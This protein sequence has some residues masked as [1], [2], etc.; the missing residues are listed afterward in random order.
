MKSEFQAK[1]MESVRVR[2][3]SAVIEPDEAQKKIAIETLKKHYG[4]MFPELFL[5][6]GIVVEKKGEPPPPKKNILPRTG[7]EKYDAVLTQC[8]SNLAHVNPNLKNVFLRAFK[9]A[10]E[11]SIAPLSDREKAILPPEKLPALVADPVQARQVI[12]QIEKAQEAVSSPLGGMR[13]S[14]FASIPIEK[15]RWVIECLLPEGLTVLGA[16]AF[17]GKSILLVQMVEHIIRG[18]AFLGQF[19]TPGADALYF[20]FEKAQYEIVSRTAGISEKTKGQIKHD[21]IYYAIDTPGLP[22]T[23]EELSE[24]CERHLETTP[25]LK[26]VIVD[27]WARIK[28]QKKGFYSDYDWETDLTGKMQNWAKRSRLALILIVHTTKQ[29]PKGEN[30]FDAFLGGSGL[31]GVTDCC[32]LLNRAFESEEGEFLVQSKIGGVTRHLKMGYKEGAG[33]WDCLGDFSPKEKN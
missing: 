14:G 8:E 7:I 5:E 26:V 12:Y 21:A 6:Y 29:P 25:N 3:Q 10:V 18:K 24:T 30:P 13:R 28:P 15:P 9:T 20:D 1:F 33:W 17:C 31:Q 22:R 11:M 32:W 2:L 19:P 4:H 23:L 27:T 16:R